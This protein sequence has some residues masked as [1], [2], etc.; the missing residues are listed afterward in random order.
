[1]TEEQGLV[2]ASILDGR[3]GGREVGWPE[4]EAWTPDRGVL[5]VH[6]DRGAEDANAWLRQGSGLDPLVVDALL[7][8]ETRPRT[9]AVGRGL[10]VILR[11]VNL[12]PGA[13]PEDMVS[14]R[15]WIDAE[16]IVSVRLRRLMAVQD[17][18]ESLARGSGPTAPGDFLVDIATRLVERMGPVIDDL[19]DRTDELEDRMLTGESREMRRSLA[20]IRHQAIVLRRYLAPQRDATARLQ[21]EE[22][23]WIDTREKARLREVTDRVVRYIEDLDSVR[24]RAAVIQDELASRLSEQMNRTMYHLTVVAS[25]MLPLGFLTGL[26][27]INVGGIPGSETPWAF[28]A[29]C[30]ILAAV[31][32]VQVVLFRRLRWL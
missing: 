30:A 28:A 5:W 17:I 6:L 10:L 24:D 15:M 25:I 32:A 20:G 1:M 12:N 9:V 27:G 8:E 21:S 29:V 7:A 22:Q 13:D 4:I 11:G 14:L 2:T 18:R 16:R 3:G 19:D 31:V 26:L 23:P